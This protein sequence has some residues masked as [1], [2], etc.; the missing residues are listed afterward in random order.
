MWAG[1]AS[2]SLLVQMKE[3]PAGIL[4]KRFVLARQRPG[5][6]DPCNP[7]QT[8]VPEL[9]MYWSPTLLSEPYVVG[10]PHIPWIENHFKC[11]QI[12]SDKEVI[13]NVQN[14]QTK[15]ILHN[16]KQWAKTCIVLLGV[17]VSNIAKTF[18]EA[19]I[20]PGQA[21]DL[22]AHPC[23][24]GFFFAGFPLKVV[25]IQS[26]NLWLMSVTLCHTNSTV[27]GRTSGTEQLYCSV[28]P[29]ALSSCTVR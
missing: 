3:T 1:R 7:Q 27:F 10:L 17:C 29:V 20:F 28:G 13:S 18:A 11:R 2:Q 9:P 23:M 14:G 26:V 22:H 24:C 4:P 6:Q 19:C 25:I 12:S 15:K 5:S 8:V 21:Q 16:L